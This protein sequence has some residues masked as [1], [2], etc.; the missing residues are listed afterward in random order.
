ME[1]NEGKAWN[2]EGRDGD[3]CVEGAASTESGQVI[4]RVGTLALIGILAQQRSMIVNFVCDQG[5]MTTLTRGE[6]TVIARDSHWLH[7]AV[8]VANSGYVG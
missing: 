1:S 5:D 3:P 7:T 4:R 8:I 6:K 2:S